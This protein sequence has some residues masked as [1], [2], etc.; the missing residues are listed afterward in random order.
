MS[1]T[2][3]TASGQYQADRA[4]PREERERQAQR[5]EG[6]LAQIR[7]GLDALESSCREEPEDPVSAANANANANATLPADPNPCTSNVCFLAGDHAACH[8]SHGCNNPQPSL[9][10]Q[11][12]PYSPADPTHATYR[13]PLLPADYEAYYN[14]VGCCDVHCPPRQQPTGGPHAAPPFAPGTSLPAA[15]TPATYRTPLLPPDYAA[16]YNCTGCCDLPGSATHPPGGSPNPTSPTTLTPC[17]CAS[18]LAAGDYKACHG[19]AG[20]NFTPSPEWEVAGAAGHGRNMACNASGCFVCLPDHVP[21]VEEER[22]WVMAEGP[23]CCRERLA[24][25]RGLTVWGERFCF[26]C[27][28]AGCRSRCGWCEGAE[29]ERAEREQAERERAEKERA[30]CG[31]EAFFDEYE[32]AAAEAPWYAELAPQVSEYEAWRAERLWEKHGDSDS[33]DDEADAEADEF[34]EAA[35]KGVMDREEEE[36]WRAERLWE[37]YGKE[38]EEDADDE[39]EGEDDEQSWSELGV[40]VEGMENAAPGARCLVQ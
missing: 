3:T 21:S 38:E 29:K 35:A 1:N 8:P 6:L 26:W 27:L 20:C 22:A 7:R 14:C 17:F 25:E 31:Y 40:E 12:T 18:H 5:I 10:H 4:A 15:P 24:E 37:K 39:G 23:C 36:E 16:Y 9:G 11:A 32:D 13:G 34:F 28:G 33:E 30:E 2:S 19:C